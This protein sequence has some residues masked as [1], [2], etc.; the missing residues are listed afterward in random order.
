MC[1]AQ[2]FLIDAVNRGIAAPFDAKRFIYGHNAT[3]YAKWYR[4]NTDYEIDY[5]ER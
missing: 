2:N 4:T 1:S 5:G 3:N